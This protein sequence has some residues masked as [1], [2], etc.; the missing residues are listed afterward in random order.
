MPIIDKS[1]PERSVR[2]LYAG[3]IGE[4]QGLHVILPQLAKRMDSRIHF[5]IVGDGGRRHMLSDALAKQGVTN[6]ELVSPVGRAEL[7]QAYHMA[8]VLFLHLN[9]YDSFERVLPSKVFE[10]AAMGKPV[11]AGVSGYAAEFVRTEVNNSAVFHPCDVD[12]AVRVFEKLILKD[13]MRPAFAVKYARN[14]ISL[15]MAQDV[16]MVMGEH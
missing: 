16:M 6:V 10:Y 4:G 8:D 11:W 1:D 13:T 3:N 14:A 7:I 12:G 9:A 2:V 5:T 15:Q